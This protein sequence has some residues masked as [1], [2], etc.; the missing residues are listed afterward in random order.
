M[1]ACVGVVVVRL[2]LVWWWGGGGGVACLPACGGGG[3]GAVAVVWW[4]CCGDGGGVLWGGYGVGR[5]WCGAVGRGGSSDRPCGWLPQQHPPECSR[6]PLR[7]LETSQ[8]MG[9]EM[10]PI[11]NP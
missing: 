2:P 9:A 6:S 1:V 8:R 5:V 11:I 10:F 4:G 3:G 7:I